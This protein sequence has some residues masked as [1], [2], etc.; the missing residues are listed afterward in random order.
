LSTRIEKTADRVSEPFNFLYGERSVVCV[1]D[2]RKEERG[3][4]VYKIK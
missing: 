4:I 3:H 1:V 2:A